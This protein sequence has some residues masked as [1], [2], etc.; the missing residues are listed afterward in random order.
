MKKIIWD[1]KN[2][3]VKLVIDESNRILEAYTIE[4]NQKNYLK[5]DSPE[6]TTAIKNIKENEAFKRNVIKGAGDVIIADDYKV[7]TTTNV[8]NNP[9]SVNNQVTQT[10]PSAA[11]GAAEAG[12]AGKAIGTLID[13]IS[14]NPQIYDP[15]IKDNQNN[16]KALIYPLDLSKEQD[17]MVITM[18]RYKSVIREGGSESRN[19]SDTGGDGKPL[20]YIIFPMPN[21]LE[22]VSKVEW[23]ADSLPYSSIIGSAAGTAL[24]LLESFKKGKVDNP[25]TRAGKE[26][27]TKIGTGFDAVKSALSGI[28][29]DRF[30]SRGTGVITNPNQ[31][32]LFT[33]NGLRV[34]KYQFDLFPR[35]REESLEIR[36]IVRVF[37][38]GMLPRK[39][40]GNIFVGAPNTFRIRF[41]KGGTDNDILPDVRRHKELALTT[42]VADAIPGDTWMTYNDNDHST[43]G[44]KILMGFTELTPIYYN[45]YLGEGPQD[46]DPKD[47]N[48]D[49]LAGSIGY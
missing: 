24:N 32:L 6:V 33:G 48:G 5:S 29:Y 16:T 28:N 10:G 40:T 22:D 21:E 18:Y 9:S 13:A 8:D 44:F 37:R 27:L 43:L 25:K 45:D 31:D 35:N 23:S 34:F 2:N 38:Q 15:I 17:R 30:L 39:L 20:A 1:P 46:Q 19:L 14:T 4:N 41:I 26:Q 36:N 47:I 12:E 3:N 7:P 11:F 49:K 42:F